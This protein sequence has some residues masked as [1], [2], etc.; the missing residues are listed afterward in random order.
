MPS[1]I[2]TPHRTEALLD[3]RPLGAG[4]VMSTLWF[5]PGPAR[6]KQGGDSRNFMAGD[7]T[8]LSLGRGIRCQDAASRRG[9][10]GL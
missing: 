3:L 4:M 9:P 5:M 10:D 7:M 2:F 1:V 8:S 6:S